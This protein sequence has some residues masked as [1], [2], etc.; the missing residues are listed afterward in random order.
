MPDSLWTDELKDY[1]VTRARKFHPYYENERLTGM[2]IGKDDEDFVNEVLRKK[3][4][5]KR[6]MAK[7]N[8]A[9][10]RRLE[11]GFPLGKSSA[12]RIH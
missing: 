4:K 5:Y 1:R 11:L 8:Q 2:M 3:A 9:R 7:T 12:K 10:E 6:A